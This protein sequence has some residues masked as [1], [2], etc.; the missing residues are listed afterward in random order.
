MTVELKSTK[1]IRKEILILIIPIILESILSI[2]AGI[3]STALVGRLDPLSISAQ[4]V[5]LRITDLI[6]VLWSGL[7]IGAM[8]CI[9]SLYGE[10]KFLKSKQV[11]QS[12]TIAS[13]IL[14]AVFQIILFV[15]PYPFLRFFSND[16]IILE[17]AKSYM[18]VL[19]LGFPFL[20]LTRFNSAAFQGYGDT[21]TPMALQLIINIV[22]IVAGYIF[23][24]VFNW[25]LIGAAWAT[26]L[27]QFIG[28][29]AGLYLIYCRNGL[30]KEAPQHVS[31]KKI[32]KKSIKE[33]YS[34]GIP[35]AL[36]SAFWQMSA[37]ILS[38]VVLF[39]GPEAFAAYNLG[40]QAETIMELPAIGFTVAATALAGKAF[41]KKD[42]Y[43]FKAYYREQLKINTFISSITSLLLILLPGLFMAFVTNNP[44]LQAIGKVY[45][46][47]M[48]FIQIPQNIQRTFTGTLYAV[49]YKRIPMY[50]SGFGTW[51]IRIPFAIAAA[52]LF[53]FDIIAIW[54]IIA[55]DQIIRCIITIIFIKKKRVLDAVELAEELTI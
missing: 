53:K 24:F 15:A 45:L 12:I 25:G 13:L 49:G 20:I 38:K 31:L 1:E 4:G 10:G 52:Y 6:G 19:V 3:V 46:V 40:T 17:A 16:P 8:V 54:I 55:I 48:G 50:I 14:G 39:Y 51:V 44:E 36:D 35:A 41:G 30:F 23:I 9:A 28:A 18:N 27:S 22:N 34:T 26:L 5:A 32:D 7:R 29:L 47:I 2:L 43:L 11:F 37:I 33:S 42:S 21:K